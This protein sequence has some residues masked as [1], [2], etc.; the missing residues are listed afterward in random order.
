MRT[1]MK[2]ELRRAQLVDTALQMARKDG[3]SAIK[4]DQLAEA[5]GMSYGVI[6]W[7]FPGAGMAAVKSATIDA[8]IERL[9]TDPNDKSLLTVLAQALGEGNIA[10]RAAPAKLKKAALTTLM[11]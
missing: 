5:A 11:S 10:A 2:A 6:H 4:R 3:F 8:V 9:E 1:K 7:V